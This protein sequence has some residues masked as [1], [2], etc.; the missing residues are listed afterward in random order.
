M[1]HLKTFIIGIIMLVTA[2]FFTACSNTPHSDGESEDGEEEQIKPDDGGEA[3]GGEILVAYFSATNNTEVVAGYIKSKLGADIF[4]IV[5]TVPY[6]AADLNYND[7]SSRTSIENRTPTARPEIGV[8][9]EKIEKYKTVFIGYPIWHGQA[10]KI[11]YTFLENYDFS[12][13][14]VIP[15]CTSASSGIGSSDTNLHSLAPNAEWKSG[16]RFA[17]NASKDSVSQWVDSL[18]I[19]IEQEI[20]TMQI[21][22]TIGETKLTATLVD[23]SATAALKE[24]LKT[25]PITINMSDYGGFE[26]VGGFGFSLPTSNE[27]VT[28]EPCD[29]VL[30]QGNQ[31]VIF[32]GS[33]SWSYTRLGKITGVTASELKAVLGSGSVTVTLSIKA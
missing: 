14:T 5:P 18:N 13:I 19:K 24:K 28:T 33:N 7:Y 3:S 29:F 27:K 23:N 12:G 22:F 6:T 2:F 4:E 17:Q 8:S 1:K 16:K 31:L 20:N 9:F 32:Y 25:A 10:P 26:K 30:Y 21:Y 15:F 11:I